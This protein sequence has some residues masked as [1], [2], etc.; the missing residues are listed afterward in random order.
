MSN[1][2]AKWSAK[3]EQGIRSFLPYG[4]AKSVRFLLINADLVIVDRC[5]VCNV[6]EDIADTFNELVRIHGGGV[7][8]YQLEEK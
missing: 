4:D 5:S 6:A 7:F 3:D 8:I 2:K 1:T